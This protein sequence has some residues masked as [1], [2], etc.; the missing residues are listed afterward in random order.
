MKTQSTILSAIVALA[1]LSSCVKEQD[2][3][4]VEGPSATLTTQAQVDAFEGQQNMTSLIITGT[5]ITDISKINVTAV[6]NLVIRN[7]GLVDLGLEN[8]TTITGNAEISGNKALESIRVSSFKFI[9]GNLEIKDNPVLDDISG[10]A[11]L[12]RASGK[13]S[14]TGNKI[15]G[16]DKKNAPFTYGFN[17]LKYLMDNLVVEPANISMSNNHPMAAT[18]PELIGKMSEDVVLSYVITSAD[19][20]MNIVS[21]KTKD[22][23]VR[24][25]G[26]TDEVM[27]LLGDSITEV[28]GDFL[29]EGT[30]VTKAEGFF[31]KVQFKGSITLKD[32][33]YYCV[34][35]AQGYWDAGA[36]SAIDHIN[37][38]LKLINIPQLYGRNSRST[39]FGMISDIEGSLIMEE[40]PYQEY[41]FANLETVGGDFI[42]RE[43]GKT[44]VKNGYS[45]NLNMPL[46]SVG[47][48]LE[49]VNNAYANT[50]H[51]FENLREVGGNIL[52]G[53]NAKKSSDIPNVPAE[54]RQNAGWN[55]A[56]SWKHYHIYGGT[57][58]CY[59]QDGTT[60]VDLS[61]VPYVVIED[62]EPPTYP[63]TISS[64]ADLDALKDSTTAKTLT[65]SGPGITQQV[66]DNITSKIIKV[67]EETYFEDIDLASADFS[68][69]FG[70]K[71]ERGPLVCAGDVYFSRLSLGSIDGFPESFDNNL[72]FE[73][74][75]FGGA[76]AAALNSI[77]TIGGEL[78]VIQ[79]KTN[80]NFAFASLSTIGGNFSFV[81]NTGAAGYNFGIQIVGGDVSYT[82]NSEVLSLKGFENIVKIKGALTID[83][84]G[85]IV[86]GTE[87]AAYGFDL[88]KSWIDANKVIGKIT[89]TYKDGTPVNFSGTVP[90]GDVVLEG[91]NE[92]FKYVAV[93]SGAQKIKVKN[94]TING[95]GESFSNSELAKLRNKVEEIE[96]N[97]VVKNIFGWTTLDGYSGFFG[98]DPNNVTALLPGSIVCKGGISII[99]C[100]DLANIG[101][102]RA[103]S[104]IGGDL[105][106]ED[107]AKILWSYKSLNYITEIKGTL[108]VKGIETQMNTSTLDALRK[109][110]GDV[111]FENDNNWLFQFNETSVLE[112][113]GGQLRIV[114]NKSFNNFR[115]FEKIKGVKSVYIRNNASN[116]GTVANVPGFSLI[117]SW[118]DNGYVEYG[119][120]ECYKGNDEKVNF[121]PRK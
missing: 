88:V 102:F 95:L 36:F 118:I 25:E 68:G 35:D 71:G 83:G 104:V 111:I 110:G 4:M 53:G 59:H 13:M 11:N 27:A 42:I 56:S 92:F 10:L 105:V 113:I 55:L 44:K 51:G 73:E 32:L 26:I 49:Y 112:T 40:C 31:D 78:S 98:C 8:L 114:G 70:T 106:L 63:L 19:D 58:E 57:L 115:G 90:E 48:N 96:G 87:G 100:P 65:V 54:P 81:R 12:R 76:S 9:T 24:G 41:M 91:R 23:T 1:C 62:L 28:D 50:L 33:E 79:C 117:Q 74:V 94:L 46:R 67:K 116:I 5:G 64:Q 3:W 45:W 108:K 89:C 52:I 47:G 82:K 21:S 43:C 75:T 99:N 30:Q 15:L 107:C 119:N 20:I 2:I 86:Y 22:L 16:E 77:R 85:G 97:L 120:V 109:V 93:E 7:T 29:M 14:F 38:D 101:G 34:D 39:G 6:H 103:M 37:G 80:E 69:I 17:V 18:A 60:P 84:N 121:T 66:L 72:Y 61:A